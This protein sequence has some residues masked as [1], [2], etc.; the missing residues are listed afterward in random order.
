MAEVGQ[1]TQ[2]NS[3]QQ[4]IVEKEGRHRDSC[5]S[6][7]RCAKA[8]HWRQQCGSHGSLSHVQEPRKLVSRSGATEACLTFRSHGS[9]SHVQEPRKL[10]SLNRAQ[11][12]R[13]LPHL[14]I[15][16]PRFQVLQ[17]FLAPP[18]RL[19]LSSL[20]P[21][22][23][24]GNPRFQVLQPFQAPPHRLT[25]SSL[26]P[27]PWPIGDPRFQVL[28][29]F[30]A[31]PHR[32]TPVFQYLSRK[33]GLDS[34][35]FGYLQTIFGVLQL[36]CG[37]VF[38]RYSVCVQGALPTVTQ[39]LSDTMAGTS[40]VPQ[41]HSRPH[42]DNG[43]PVSQ[44][45]GSAEEL[46]PLVGSLGV[47]PH[48]SHDPGHSQRDS[49]IG[50][51]LMAVSTQPIGLPGPG[52]SDSGGPI[53]SRSQCYGNAKLQ[54]GQGHPPTSHIGQSSKGQS[55]PLVS[56]LSEAVCTQPHWDAGETESL[57]GGRPPSSHPG[58]QAIH[59]HL[60]SGLP[61]QPLGKGKG[62]PDCLHE[63]LTRP[64]ALRFADQCGARAALT[65]SFL[66]AL[67]LYLL[68]V[69]ASSPALP[70]VYLLFASRLPG[71]LMHTMPAAQM[72]IT[73]LLAPEERPAALGRLGLCFG[74]G[75]ILGSLL[76]G[77]LISAYG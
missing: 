19:T 60:H 15:G 38:G 9:L 47:P 63:G 61:G 28:G 6:S 44:P 62:D 49:V 29:S 46:W 74:G 7:G 36:L 20:L 2:H 12:L 59:P 70:G 31:P 11:A 57:R 43:T 68:L 69:A 55:N 50:E 54:T 24:I 42:W 67:A 64:S 76:G 77:T 18:H 5:H 73:D 14:P 66:A 72:V 51:H 37:P 39:A 71:A 75:V 13:S 48:A 32:L 53:H 40:Q 33:L 4:T 56:Q 22:L 30:P 3:E 1:G 41:P 58:S 26:L 35:A 45:D 10:V 8:G 17:P 25:L 27:H 65:L 52:R 21:Q 16:D 34:I 23:P